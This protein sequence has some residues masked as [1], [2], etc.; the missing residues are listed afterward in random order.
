MFT[1]KRSELR[2]PQV[3]NQRGG[4]CEA[5]GFT[6]TF[7]RTVY[8]ILSNSWTKRGLKNLLLQEARYLKFVALY[9]SE[10]SSKSIPSLLDCFFESCTLH[11]LMFGVSKAT[12]ASIPPSSHEKAIRT[13]FAN[14]AHVF[15]R[16]KEREPHRGGIAQVVRSERGNGKDIEVYTLGQT[17]PFV[18]NSFYYSCVDFNSCIAAFVA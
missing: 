9:P 15:H 4:E 7:G 18:P 3:R 12:N 2:R 11:L 1:P 13:D 17:W 10:S 8:S 14:C 6:N 5:K 16:R